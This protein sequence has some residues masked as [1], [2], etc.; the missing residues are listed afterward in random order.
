MSY[1]STLTDASGKVSAGK[2]FL[3]W[4]AVGLGVLLAFAT[5]HAQVKKPNES[6]RSPEF[7]NFVVE[8]A[9][10]GASQVELRVFDPFGKMID[11]AML[12]TTDGKFSGALPLPLGI[13]VDVQ[14]QA[15]DAMGTPF[16]EGVNSAL[17][18]DMLAGHTIIGIRT[19]EDAYRGAINISP[20]KLQITSELIYGE[21]RQYQLRA[22]DAY[23]RQV[24][25]NPADVTWSVPFPENTRFIPCKPSGPG[26]A[27]IELKV[28]LP[29]NARIVA[30]LRNILCRIHQSEHSGYV[31]ISA[32][33]N[34][35]CAL[36]VDSKVLCFGDNSSSQLGRVSIETCAQQPPSYGVSPCGRMPQEITCQIGTPCTYVSVE[37]G[38]R[39]ACAV[40]TSGLVWCWGDN[41]SDQVGFT[42]PIG[43]SSSACYSVSSPS[44]VSMPSSANDLNPRIVQ[45]SAGTDHSCALSERGSVYCWGGNTFSQS[46]S[47]LGTTVQRIN[48]AEIYTSVSAGKM[49]TCATTLTGELECWGSNLSGQ[50]KLGYGAPTFYSN[51]VS[52]RANHVGVSHLSGKIDK[53]M[54][55]DGITCAQSQGSGLMCW[56]RGSL[57]GVLLT[58]T[59][60]TDLALDYY[61]PILTSS[62]CMLN[63]GVVTCG[64]W[65]VP[66]SFSSI[67]GAPNALIDIAVGKRHSCVVRS[68]GQAL[69]W[70]QD[71][72]SG[73][74]GDGTTTA[75]AIPGYVIHP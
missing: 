46:G 23:D 14:V 36:S 27:C 50:I 41:S 3:T 21:T 58:S 19:K 66:N 20:L 53:V 34:F 55:G 7:Q 16:A 30:C 57:N 2:L 28:P 40:D 43:A 74:M 18:N 63:S 17:F 29:A 22:F 51:P 49:H 59:K 37:A 15:F 25:I 39:H 64:A 4:F 68:N 67:L 69:C 71:N 48:S 70:G 10:A 26:L 56:G 65:N 73:Q 52:M 9:I 44:A 47:N 61:D 11:G 62:V 5:A 12:T 75:H 31:A 32:G 33:E 38:F 6:L 13:T 60:A 54:V 8:G 72:L 45:V 24:P 1:E 35:T 42:C